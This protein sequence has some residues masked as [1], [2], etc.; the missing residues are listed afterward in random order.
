MA[1]E[2]YI[3]LTGHGNAFHVPIDPGA[4]ADYTRPVLPGQQSDVSPLLRTE[5]ATVDTQFAR[6][7]HYFLSWQNIEHACFTALDASINNVFKVL[8]DP[9][10]RGWHAGMSVC[11]ILDQLLSIYG[12]PT[13]A[14]MELNN[15]A[16]CGVYLAANAPEIL[17]CCIKDC[18]EIAILSCNPYTDR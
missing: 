2:L 4:I 3:L 18:A 11:K 9:L 1:R 5:Q 16:F 8:S 7:K 14:A 13:P 17:F 6:Q 10:I 12:Q 15:T